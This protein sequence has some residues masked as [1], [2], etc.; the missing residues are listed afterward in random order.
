MLK[1][2]SWAHGNAVAL[3][4]PTNIILRHFGW[5][6]EMQFLLSSG[7]APTGTWGHIPIPT[8]VIINDVRLRVQKFFLLFKTGQHAAIDNI[9][10][11][12]G[13][14]RIFAQDFV[15]GTGSLARRTGDHS[16][17]ITS[18]NTFT[19]PA[20]IEPQFGLSIS[21]SFRPLAVNT[22]L[23]PVDPEGKLMITTAGADFF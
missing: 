18:D 15:A 11:Y 17:R 10:I 2:A 7:A 21:F 22:T 8:P 12:D 19:L 3:E 1:H 9:H 5:G 4:D 20:P 14:N 23:R 13:P 16:R 6:T